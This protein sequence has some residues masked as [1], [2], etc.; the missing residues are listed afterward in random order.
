MPP[1]LPLFV[2]GVTGIYRLVY[3]LTNK[4]AKE[5]LTGLFCLMMALLCSAPLYAL[6]YAKI[7]IKSVS[8]EAW[9]GKDLSLTIN[10][11]DQ[12]QSNVRLEARHFP[13]NGNSDKT[14]EYFRI[15]CPVLKY[16]EK[17]ITCN[18]GQ[19]QLKN[20]LVSADAANLAFAY[21]P[22]NQKIRVELTGLDLLSGKAAVDIDYQHNKLVANARL[23][24]LSLSSDSLSGFLPESETEFEGILSGNINLEKQSDKITSNLDLSVSG[25][26]FSNADGDI[27]ADAVSSVITGQYQYNNQSHYLNRLTVRLEQGELLTP[28]FY[29]DLNQRKAKLALKKAGFNAKKHW[30]IKHFN[31]SDN[32]LDITVSGLKGINNA[33]EQFQLSLQPVELKHVYRFYFLPVLSNDLAQLNV[34]GKL[35]ASVSMQSGEI[36]AYQLNLSDTWLAHEP[37]FGSSKFFLEN[38][39]AQLHNHGESQTDSYLKFSNASFLD[40]IEFGAVSIP[41]QTSPQSVSVHETTT[42]PVFDGAIMVETFNLDFSQDA[43]GVKFEG[44]LTPVS[45]SDVSEAFGWPEMS[46][47]V[48]GLI[49][50]VSYRDGN[51][52]LAGTLLIRAFDGNILIRDVEASHLLSSWPVL[53]ADVEMKNI[54]L[55]KLTKTFSF[56]KITGRVDGHVKKLLMENW[57]PTQFDAM[58]KTSEKSGRKRISQKAVDNISNLGGAGMAGALSRS[59]MRFFEDFGYDKLGFTCILRDGVCQMSGVE[60]ANQGYY[61]V[62]GGGIPRIDVI[63]HNKNTDWNVLLDRLANIA[64]S[65][66]PTIQ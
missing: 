50:A 60:D 63:G 47:K 9:Q 64:T 41:L 53:S 6:S 58:L 3:F 33:A 35:E 37:E 5:V 26:S 19:L 52:R 45:L 46:G 39:Q 40:T 51:A 12:S 16:S 29:T 49:P 57:Q 34:T 20:K 18:K 27:L 59:F 25:L 7:S 2:T 42:L 48:S 65:G 17:S 4:S 13:G 8:G 11:L 44:I 14:I 1:L 43:P 55:E 28:W 24:K 38:L 31:F 66:S 22:D 32:V 23:Q 36:S 54:D 61:L 56:G 62:K 10:D 30:Q 15:D 21:L